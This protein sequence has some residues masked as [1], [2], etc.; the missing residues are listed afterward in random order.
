MKKTAVQFAEN[1]TAVYFLRLTNRRVALAFENAVHY[2]FGGYLSADHHVADCGR[3]ARNKSRARVRY[4]HG[5]VL[6]NAVDIPEN[7]LGQIVAV[8]GVKRAFIV[9]KSVLSLPPK[10]Q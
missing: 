5:E 9:S 1:R 4:L 8:L 6:L 10:T 7:H 3:K 2:G